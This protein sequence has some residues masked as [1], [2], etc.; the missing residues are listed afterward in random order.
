MVIDQRLK[1]IIEKIEALGYTVLISGGYVRDAL[2]SKKSLDIDL[3]TNAP[4]KDL[5]AL[6]SIKKKRTVTIN[7]QDIHTVSEIEYEGLEVEIAQFRKEIYDKHYNLEKIEFV[8]DYKTDTK[9]RDFTINALGY[10]T[11][12]YDFH[13]GEKD[14][15][16]K[17]IKTIGNPNDRF[18]ED[19]ARMIRALRFSSTLNFNLEAKTKEALFEHKLEILKSKNINNDLKLIFQSENFDTLYE[20]YHE[21]FYLLSNG[22]FENE[23]IKDR[24]ILKDDK[25]LLA[26][27][28]YKNNLSY[29]NTIY[30]YMNFSMKDRKFALQHKTVVRELMIPLS[31]RDVTLLYIAYG[32]NSMLRLYDMLK[33]LDL[34][35]A[36]NLVYIK[37]I[38][39]EGYLKIDQDLNDSFTIK[40]KYKILKDLQMLIIREELENEAPTLLEFVHRYY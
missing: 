2:L 40:Q 17:V 34:V 29:D 19:P 35:H 36:L 39:L 20:E 27:L 7:K 5:D 13:E 14:L 4:L 8:D 38:Y 28:F 22:L 31:K 32:Q 15:N 9:R 12:L 16:N 3:A 33:D 10:N 30:D 11:K 24:S 26:Y 21:I 18:Q 23:K 37:Q 6:F 1:D 25:V